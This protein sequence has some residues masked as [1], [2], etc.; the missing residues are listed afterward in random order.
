MQASLARI[1]AWYIEYSGMLFANLLLII[2]F[3]ISLQAEA[4]LDHII[5]HHREHLREVVGASLWEF[6]DSTVKLRDM[7]FTIK[8]IKSEEEE[9]YERKRDSADRVVSLLNKETREVIAASLQQQVELLV[10][11]SRVQQQILEEASTPV[12]TPRSVR[13]HLIFECQ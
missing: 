12:R 6:V 3:V 2:I 1:Q 5:Q 13:G 9:L 10:A 11:N 4:I 7:I 8:Q